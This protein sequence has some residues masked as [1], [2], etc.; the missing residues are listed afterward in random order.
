MDALLLLQ[1]NYYDYLTNLDKET[2]PWANIFNQ[3]C[4]AMKENDSK[5]DGNSSQ[6][7]NEPNSFTEFFKCFQNINSNTGNGS[8]SK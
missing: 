3:F 2:N 6:T 1:A 5:A 7:S 4:G 8:K